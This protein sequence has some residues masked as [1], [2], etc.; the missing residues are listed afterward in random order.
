MD[1]FD[2]GLKPEWIQYSGQWIVSD[3]K[4]T[5]VYQE[6]STDAYSWIGVEN[7]NWKNYIVDLIIHIYQPLTESDEIALAV[8][9]NIVGSKYIGFEIDFWPHIYLSQISQG[10]SSSSPIAGNNK[11]FTFPLNADAQAEIKV[12]NNN[13]TLSV[14]GSTLQTINIPGYDSGGF[15]LGLYCRG[16]PQCPTFGNVKVTYLP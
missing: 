5:V 3:G 14:N 11:D 7:P 12:E 8:R 10:Y 6:S 15:R 4:L 13:Y 16:Y 9:D 2:N 1:N